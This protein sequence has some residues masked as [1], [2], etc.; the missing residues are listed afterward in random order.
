MSMGCV[1]NGSALVVSFF[2]C[3]SKTLCP[4]TV[5]WFYVGLTSPLHSI[6]EVCTGACLTP[7]LQP[8]HTASLLVEMLAVQELSRPYG[9]YRLC[10]TGCIISCVDSSLN[11]I[12]CNMDTTHDNDT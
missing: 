10:A 12:A 9:C 7:A 1:R 6:H 8:C 4:P 5:L 2:V 11:F 3:T